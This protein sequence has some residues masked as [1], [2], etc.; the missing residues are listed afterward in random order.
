MPRHAHGRRTLRNRS[1][2]SPRPTRRHRHDRVCGEL[3]GSQHPVRRRSRRCARR[4][5]PDGGAAPA[6]RVAEHRPSHDRTLDRSDRRGP[7]AELRGPAHPCRGTGRDRARPHAGP[8]PRVEHPGHA[9][10]PG[11]RAAS[12][13]RRG[14]GSHA[15]VFR[16]GGDHRALRRATGT[17]RGRPQRGDSARA[18]HAHERRRRGDVASPAR[19]ATCWRWAPSSPRK[20]LPALVEAFD[21]LALDDADLHLVVAGPDGW[22]IQAFRDAVAAATNRDRIVAV[23]RVDEERAP[24]CCAAP[25]SSRSRRA[26]RG[27][28]SRRSRRW[29]PAPPSSAR[30]P[31]RWPRSWATLPSSYRPACW[32]PTAPPGSKRSPPSLARVLADEDRRTRAHR[33]WSRALGTFHLGRDRRPSRRPLPPS[34]PAPLLVARW[35]SRSEQAKGRPSFKATLRSRQAQQHSP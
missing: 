25:P 8:V 9:R 32:Q 35:R 21:L 26:T 1:A 20:D 12:D 29:P 6:A 23:G 27:S 14:L 30:M 13:R 11:T 5:P 33:R 17:G 24:H 31:G 2:G 4:Q 10:V 22:G 15:L 16:R 28:G 7:R 3:A 18:E 19:R 34:R